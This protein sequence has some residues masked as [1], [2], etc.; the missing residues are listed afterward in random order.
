M[1][2]PQKEKRGWGK[3]GREEEK[4]KEKVGEGRKCSTDFF[5]LNLQGGCERLVFVLGTEID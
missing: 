2:I 3:K 5:I 4:K 1:F